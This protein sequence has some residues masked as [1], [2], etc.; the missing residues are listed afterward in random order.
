MKASFRIPIFILFIVLSINSLGGVLENYESDLSRLEKQYEEEIDKDYS[1]TGMVLA[2]QKYYEELD[3]ILNKCYKELMA[4]LDDEEKVALKESQREWIKFKD[5]ELKFAA[6]L[7]SK[8]DGSIWR[9]STPRVAI[10]L[11]INRIKELSIYLSDQ[12]DELF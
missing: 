1:T 10:N 11:M 4:T 5:K 2:G 9:L 8:K 12:K 7:Y 6:N 3:E